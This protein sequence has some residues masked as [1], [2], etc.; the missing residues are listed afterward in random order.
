MFSVVVVFLVRLGLLGRDGPKVTDPNICGFLQFSARICGFQKN[1]WVFCG[2]QQF[3]YG[4]IREGVIAD[5]FLL[6]SEK[7][8]QTF[9]RISAPYGS[10]TQ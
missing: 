3:T 4:V 1:E 5:N 9:R 7:F 10:L 6:I 8:P 2:F